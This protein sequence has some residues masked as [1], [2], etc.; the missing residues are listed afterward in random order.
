MGG[1]DRFVFADNLTLSGTAPTIDG[2]LGNDILDYSAFT[3]T[4]VNVDMQSGTAMNISG[5]FTGIETVIGGRNNVLYGTT[6]NDTLTGGSGNDTLVGRG[7]DDTYIFVNGWGVDTVIELANEGN[8]TFDFSAVTTALNF[9][10][11]NIVV[12][13]TSGANSVTHANGNVENVIGSAGADTFNFAGANNFNVRG[14]TGNDL[15]CLRRCGNTRRH[16]QRRRWHR[17]ARLL[18]IHHGRHCESL[19]E[20]NINQH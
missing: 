19:D 8:D 9:N 20:F 5:G 10:F 14:N 2:G 11:N 16:A 7:G 3:T 13:V 17:Y 12:T 1:D 15:L 18:G 4:L 6:G